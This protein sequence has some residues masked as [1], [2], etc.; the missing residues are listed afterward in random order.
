MPLLTFEE[1]QPRLNPPVS[2]WREDM[3]ENSEPQLVP[4]QLRCLTVRN[5]IYLEVPRYSTEVSW[6][7]MLPLSI[8]AIAIAI[9][10]MFFFIA[11]QKMIGGYVMI[12]IGIIG[13]VIPLSAGYWG[14]KLSYVAPRDQPLRLNRKRQKL[15]IFNYNSSHL[16]W[17]KWPV[18]IKCYNWSDVHGEIIF[19]GVGG[20][21]GYHLYGAICEPGTYNVV[22]RFLLAK[23]WE[24]REQ[25]NQIWSYLCIYMKGE[26]DL[27]EP[28]FKGRPDFWRPRKADKWPEDMERESTTAP[29]EALQS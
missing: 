8:F 4:P 23:E 27:P 22:D 1:A 7:L 5:D 18:T 17:L 28:G 2:C 14:L 25:L 11:M 10:E 15:Y 16:P 13:S 3:P 21:R 20:D 6:W 19:S 12:I 24:E 26:S 29:V 9:G